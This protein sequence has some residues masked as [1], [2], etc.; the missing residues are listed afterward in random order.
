M[1]VLAHATQHPAAIWHGRLRATSSLN[2]PANAPFRLADRMSK[3]ARRVNFGDL[4]EFGLPVPGKVPSPGCAHRQ[5]SCHC[6]PKVIDAFRDRSIEVVAGVEAFD[7][8]TVSLHGGAI[9]SPPRF[10]RQATVD[11][12]RTSATL[13]CSTSRRAICRRRGCGC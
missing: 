13:A 2:S 6:D 1:V 4:T 11:W 3:L 7:A 8:N 9:S 5:G 12:T 10:R